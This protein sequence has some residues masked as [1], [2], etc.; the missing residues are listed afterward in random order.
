MYDRT[1]LIASV[2][3]KACLEFVSQMARHKSYTRSEGEKTLA[4][5][6]VERM[7]EIGLEAAL[8]PV[9][10]GRYNAIGTWRGSGGGPSLL[11]S[12]HLDTNPVSE[13]W[14]VDPWGG[15][16]D[17]K[18]IYG[19][20]VSNMKAGDAAYFCA[21]RTLVQAGVRLRGDVILTF[22]V[23]ELQSGIGTRAAIA[24]GLRADYFINSEPTDL[25][26]MTTH[27][28]SVKF[29][30]ELVG[31]TRHM[32]KREE[33]V[34]AIAA[35]CELV[36]T[37]THLTF[38]GA[39]DEGH[40]RINRVN[41]GVLHGALGKDFNEW[42][43]PQVADFVRLKGAARYAPS[44]RVEDVLGEIRAVLGALEAKFPG[45][46]ATLEAEDANGVPPF[47]VDPSA[48]IVK[49]VNEAYRE[50]RGEAQPTGIIL[51]SSYYGTDAAHLAAQMGMEGVVCGPG[52]RYNTM[53]DER[54][55]VADYLDC[56]RLYM[57]AMLDIC[58]ASSKGS[59]I[60]I[61]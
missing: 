36:P 5:W 13:G 26:A 34:D 42:R 44:Q 48:R 37:L 57:L 2:D 31:I 1:S 9:P 35:A 38:S 41:I 4:R 22:V 43:A 10:G 30:V 55:D 12:G 60:P 53:P 11:F 46:R 16:V 45:L 39:K 50:I 24:Q 40:R 51:P 61:A 54:V 28:G 17:D 59:R 25:A 14:T 49:V 18:F 52:G 58:E 29:T 23:G 32:S 21:L 19:I 27:A 47:E 56:V 33:A 6:M 20:G 7:R 15:L 3:D 8:H